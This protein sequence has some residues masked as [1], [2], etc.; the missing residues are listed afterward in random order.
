[1]DVLIK[2]LSGMHHDLFGNAMWQRRFIEG[3]QGLKYVLADKIAN[4][5]IINYTYL[6]SAVTKIEKRRGLRDEDLSAICYVADFMW[7]CYE[8]KVKENCLQYVQA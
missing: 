5:R 8:G 4:G 3:V 6:V 1:M 7:T 2:Q